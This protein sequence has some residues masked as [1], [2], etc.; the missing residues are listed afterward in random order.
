MV[1][2][3]RFL[4]QHTGSVVWLSVVDSRIDH[5][6][7]SWYEGKHLRGVATTDLLPL[8]RNKILDQTAQSTSSVIEDDSVSHFH[9]G[10]QAIG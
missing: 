8:Q 1:Q 4:N 10:V 5:L 7:G 2:F 6:Q 3:K 9:Q